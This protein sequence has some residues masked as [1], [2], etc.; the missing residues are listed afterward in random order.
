MNNSQALNIFNKISDG[1]LCA[2]L[3]SQSGKKR[4][5]IERLGDSHDDK[6]EFRSYYHD[7]ECWVNKRFVSLSSL[8][9]AHCIG[10][11]N[12]V[13]FPSVEYVS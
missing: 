4:I 2:V 7:G 6:F 10:T 11:I 12:S 5:E 8:E 3:T 1:E 9:I 13:K